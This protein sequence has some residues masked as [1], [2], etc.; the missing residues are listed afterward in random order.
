MG[1]SICRR[2]EPMDAVI[3]DMSPP[4]LIQKTKT[5]ENI[6]II[7]DLTNIKKNEENIT[8]KVKFNFYFNVFLL[9]RQKW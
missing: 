1:C 6:Q 5:P 7:Q 4:P 3:Q 8:I 9:R 2:S